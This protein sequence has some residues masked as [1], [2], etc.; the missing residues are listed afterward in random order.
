MTGISVC[1]KGKFDTEVLESNENYLK[2]TPKT[3]EMVRRKSAR[4][5]E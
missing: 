1:D 4:P 2:I 3:L 5:L